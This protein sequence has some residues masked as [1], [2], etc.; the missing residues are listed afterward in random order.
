MGPSHPKNWQA[1]KCKYIVCR[2]RDHMIRNK[3]DWFPIVRGD[4]QLSLTVRF[5]SQQSCK[6][7]AA[8]SH[9]GELL[10]HVIST[11]LKNVNIRIEVRKGFNFYFAHSPT[12]LYSSK[13][14]SLIF[15]LYCRL[16]KYWC[17]LHV[18]GVGV[19]IGR[20]ILHCLSHVT[21]FRPGD[22]SLRS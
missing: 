21:A 8:G 3:S 16:S 5:V 4:P 6:V 18:H 10:S 15:F 19:H 12:H 20:M 2:H 9:R 17:K 11:L 14:C 13:Q 7:S 1:E 22:W